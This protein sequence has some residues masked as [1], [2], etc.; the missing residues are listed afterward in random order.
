MKALQLIF[1]KPIASMKNLFGNFYVL[2][3]ILIILS[4]KNK[5]AQKIFLFFLLPYF[6]I[7]S[8]LFG[9]DYRA[10]SLAMPAT[11]LLL[12]DRYF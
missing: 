6:L 1:Q 9:L 5:I 11:G 4:L 8:L 12:C 2:I 3:T 7:Y 10:F